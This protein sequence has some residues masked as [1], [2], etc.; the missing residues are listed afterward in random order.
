MMLDYPTDTVQ[1]SKVLARSRTPF[2]GGVM[3]LVNRH[4]P[5]DDH[6]IAVYLGNSSV[7]T[8]RIFHDGA[9]SGLVT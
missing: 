4:A 5:D 7:R 6:K 9:P 3:G 1:L 8:A 2:A